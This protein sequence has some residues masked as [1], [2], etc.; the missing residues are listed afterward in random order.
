[1]S[2]FDVM[3]DLFL[4]KDVYQQMNMFLLYWTILIVYFPTS[5]PS[6]NLEKDKSVTNYVP[7]DIKS[8]ITKG[9]D[10]SLL[11]PTSGKRE[12]ATPTEL[13][14]HVKEV[15][16]VVVK[17]TE[18][19]GLIDAKAASQSIQPLSEDE[20]WHHF[21]AGKQGVIDSARFLITF[22]L[23]TTLQQGGQPLHIATIHGN[24]ERIR[25]L[26]E[27]QDVDVDLKKF[28]DGITPLII[29]SILGNDGAVDLLIKLDA[30][31]NQMS[32]NGITPLIAASTMGHLIVV[33]KLLKAGAEPDKSHPYA[34]TSSL[35]FASEMGNTQII[36]L[37]CQYGANPNSRKIN[38]GTP[39]H[40]AADTNQSLAVRVL[41]QNCSSDTELLLA[42]DTTPLYLAAQRGFVDVVQALLEV[43]NANPNYVM[44]KG[45]HKG[46]LIVYEN[47]KA[48]LYQEKNTEIGNGATALH[49]AVENGHL[50]TV[51]MLLK[52]G[53]KQLPSMEGSTPVLIAL[54]YRHP[55]I[56]M[57]LLSK[58]QEAHVNIAT[59]HDGM[60]PLFAAAQYGYH[61]VVDR[62]LARGAHVNAKVKGKEYTAKDIA[63]SYRHKNVL[64]IMDCYLDKENMCKD[65]RCMRQEICKGLPFNET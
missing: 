21:Q 53:A 60:F 58:G 54:Q 3:E 47:E 30:N 26:V 50:L 62:L 15:W 38:G 20:A 19:A 36:S 1:M 31:V 46:E 18:S 56:A 48:K 42:G 51:R 17:D 28:S 12:L 11:V 37:L 33:G 35:H 43:G 8:S 27:R 25:H 16:D 61:K 55:R 57:N 32:R 22:S 45:S 64:Q 2:L 52:N 4:R 59:P 10:L 44:P 41:T 34:Q 40:V 23:L 65:K 5:V 13:Y 9:K 63:K 39:L 14:E 24:L 29:A 49:A 7:L 6:T